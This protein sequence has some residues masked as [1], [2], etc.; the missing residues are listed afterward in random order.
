MPPPVCVA[1]LRGRKALSNRFLR[2]VLSV[3][4]TTS[5]LHFELG[6][7]SDGGV[8]VVFREGGVPCDR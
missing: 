5:V 6:Q 4:P 2:F 3:G 8:V 7:V 1:N